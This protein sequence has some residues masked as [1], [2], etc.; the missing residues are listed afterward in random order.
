MQG[1]HGNQSTSCADGVTQRNARTVG[2][3]FCGVETQIAAHGAGLGGKGFVGFD[4]IQI[5]HGQTGFFQRG[6]RSGNGADTHVFGIN[7]SVCVS[8]QTCQRLQTACFR[9]ASFHQHHS[10]GR[11]VNTGCVARSYRAVFFQENGF[12]F[13]HV[14]HCAV[15]AIVFVHF[16]SDFTF[17]AFQ[18]HGHDLT[19]E[20]TGFNR[21]LGTVVAFNSQCVL[22][23]AGDAPFSGDIFRC[24][25]HVNNVEGVMQRTSHHVDHFGI[26]HACAPT[27]IEAG[28]RCAAHVFSTATDGYIGIAQQNALACRNNRLQTRT[29]QTVHVVSGRTFGTTTV[30]GSDAGKIHIFGFGIHNV[31]EHDVTHIFSFH[32]TACQCFTHDLRSQ[33]AGRNIF[34][35]ATKST[36]GGTDGAYYYYFT[37]HADLLNVFP[38]K[39]EKLSM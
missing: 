3:H 35:T 15:G 34:Q 4:N 2:V 29:A 28:E 37:G 12:Q 31:T 6:L 9:S 33:L 20:I 1:F 18:H 13:R 16:V 8:N 38:A 19:F 32:L 39:N 17:A 21:T 26:A 23:F 24:H 36:N 22:V 27:H 14:S 25:A 7:A 11:I 30:D 5:V 10:G